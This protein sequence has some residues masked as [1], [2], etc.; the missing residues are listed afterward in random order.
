MVVEGLAK[1][2]ADLEKNVEAIHWHD[3]DWLMEETEPVNGLALIPFQKYISG[4][5]RAFLI[6]NYIV[7][8]KSQGS[9]SC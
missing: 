1:S 9:K 7:Y 6:N 8:Y 5:F 4:S 3:G 2:I